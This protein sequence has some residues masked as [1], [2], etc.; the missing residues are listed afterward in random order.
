M[1]RVGDLPLSL[2]A[3]QAKEIPNIWRG[4]DLLRY[5]IIHSNDAKMIESRFDNGRCYLPEYVYW[6]LLYNVFKG[7]ILKEAH[8]K[9]QIFIDRLS[10]LASWRIG[11]DVVEID[12]DV[13]VALWETPIDNVPVEILRRMP[14]WC[15]YFPVSGCGDRD[16]EGD[17]FSFFAFYNVDI[18]ND[19]ESTLELKIVPISTKKLVKG[20]DSGVIESMQEIVFG[21]SINLRLDKSSI[22]EMLDDALI[23]RGNDI[24]QLNKIPEYKSVKEFAQR[25]VSLIL[26]ATTE[27]ENAQDE[28]ISGINATPHVAK[29]TKDGWR[30][31]APNKPNI[32]QLG[33]DIGTQ[34]RAVEIDSESKKNRIGHAS[35]RPH[36]R[37]AHWQT[38]WYGKRVF[39]KNE[40]PIPQTPK[41]RFLLA[42]PVAM[43]ENKVDNE[44]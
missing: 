12:Q 37:R 17:V 19:K 14:A 1:K 27:Y 8:Y 26:Y 35:P 20:I 38:Y 5:Q 2:L 28:H 23:A 44:E 3:Q 10:A 11:Q 30:F 4:L 33:F 42:V 39:K 25:C 22:T 40:T 32:W 29:K 24:Q 21:H 9:Q 6:K 31:F 18:R 7:D 15:L 16:G 43:R 36:I 41:A 13:L 34:I